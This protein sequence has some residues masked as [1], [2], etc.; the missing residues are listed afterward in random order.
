MRN[1]PAHPLAIGRTWLR[2]FIQLARNDKWC[3][4]PARVGSTRP[5]AAGGTLAEPRGS[6][7][8]ALVFSPDAM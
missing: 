1:A 4:D 6:L 7:D 3:F 5:L 8:R 2:R